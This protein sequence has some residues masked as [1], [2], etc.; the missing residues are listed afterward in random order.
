MWYKCEVTHGLHGAWSQ[1]ASLIAGQF[2]MWNCLPLLKSTWFIY[3]GEGKCPCAF[4]RLLSAFIQMPSSCRTLLCFLSAAAPALGE[5]GFADGTPGSWGGLGAGAGC[6]GLGQGGPTEGAA[7]SGHSKGTAGLRHQRTSQVQPCLSTDVLADALL[8]GPAAGC[9]R[10]G[11]CRGRVQGTNPGGMG[12]GLI[13]VLQGQV[14]LLPPCRPGSPT[15]S[16]LSEGLGKRLFHRV[17]L[18]SP[19]VAS[20]ICFSAAGQLQEDVLAVSIAVWSLAVSV[21]HQ[22]GTRT[23]NIFLSARCILA[24]ELKPPMSS[25]KNRWLIK[26]KYSSFRKHIN[27]CSMLIFQWLHYF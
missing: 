8:P 25:L 10:M 17:C 22:E 20:C 12:D 5:V 27:W 21:S 24:A 7:R 2:K 18:L 23:G 15:G 13:N 4:N 9:R 14:S 3:L 19:T 16:L 6:H 26:A 1:Q 11:L